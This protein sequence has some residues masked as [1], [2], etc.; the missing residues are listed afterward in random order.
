[1]DAMTVSELAGTVGAT[2]DTVR[3]YER[4]GLMPE[5]ERTSSGYRQYYEPAVQRLKFI[6]RAQRFGLRLE[7]IGELL[8][9]RD[10]GLCPCG[11]ARTLLHQRIEELEDQIDSLTVLRDD[12][13]GMLEGEAR[14]QD[15]WPCDGG[16]IQ[17]ERMR[18]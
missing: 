14:Q 11:H 12:I 6:K 3:Y 8:D 10:R 13:R 15:A 18:S 1:M 16:L 4:I 7:E 9:V 17:I 5:P 2:A